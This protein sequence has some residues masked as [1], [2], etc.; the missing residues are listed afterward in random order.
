MPAWV[1]EGVSEYQ[2]RLPREWGFQW[3]ELPLGPRGKSQSSAKAIAAEGDAM[4]AA[5]NSQDFVVALDVQGKSWSTEILA[6]RIG[7][8]QL[9]GYNMGLLIGG[10]DG[11]C[12]RC[13]D[14]ANMR[15]SLSA[16]TLPHPLVRVVLIEQLYRAWSL[17]NNH[18]YHK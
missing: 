7:Q 18:P 14:R 5:L 9:E 16:L 6:E 2:K 4:L 15:W 17:L 13:L 1:Q 11:L 3:L 12:P 8:W 10:P